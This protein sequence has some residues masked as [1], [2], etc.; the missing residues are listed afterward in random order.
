MYF[1]EPTYDLDILARRNLHIH[2]LFSGCAK[3]EMVLDDIIKTAENAGLEAIAITDHIYRED[4]YEGFRQNVKDLR[5]QLSRIDTDIKV[6]IGGELSAYGVDKYSFKGEEIELDY[7][8]WAH[9]HYH[10]TGWEQP[11]DR[12][13]EGYKKHMIA[14]ITNLIKADKADC[15]AHPFH[16]SYLT[17][18]SRG[19]VDFSKGSVPNCF[20][21][22][23]IGDLLT[24]AKQH[25]TAFEL[26]LNVVPAFPEIYRKM[27]NIGKEVGA[28]FNIGTDA[29]KLENIDTKQFIDIAKRVLIG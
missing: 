26:N 22:N 5:E 2:A 27:Y 25:E 6:Y 1:H 14:T 10:V 18:S 11:E 28:Q 12:S 19:L 17:N 4:Q 8:L 20:T 29:H 21:E 15:I 7:R 23:E 13:P 16:D 9:N 24:L 3:R